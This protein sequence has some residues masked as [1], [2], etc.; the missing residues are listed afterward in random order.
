M[1]RLRRWVDRYAP[2]TVQEDYDSA[3]LPPL[4]ETS[5]FEG[6]FLRIQRL[7]FVRQNHYLLVQPRLGSFFEW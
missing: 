2:P 7:G 1:Q 4:Y 3:L 5:A 6:R